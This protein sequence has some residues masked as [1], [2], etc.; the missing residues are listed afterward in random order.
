MTTDPPPIFVYG[1]LTDASQVEA[2]L[3]DW[4]FDGGAV[5]EGLHS[6][7]GRYPTL[8]PGGTATGRLLVTPELDRLDAYEDVDRGLYVRVAVPMAEGDRAWLYVGV[9]G[10]LDAPAEWP[11]DGPFARRVRAYVNDA[12]VRVRR[13]GNR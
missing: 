3:D 7:E 4:R 9:P 13:A 5:L 12:S 11:G 10:R 6:V 8:A 2:L 1:T